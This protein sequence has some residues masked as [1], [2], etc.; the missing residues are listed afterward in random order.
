MQDGDTPRDCN[1]VCYCINQIP[2][3]IGQTVLISFTIHL[4][5]LALMHQLSYCLLFVKVGLLD[6][7]KTIFDISE[8][9]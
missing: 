9:M 8:Q 7:R 5:Y 2:D 6:P 3:I 1:T 4:S